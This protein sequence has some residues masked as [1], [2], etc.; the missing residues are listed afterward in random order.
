MKFTNN[1]PHGN[2]DSTV[3]ESIKLIA[4]REQDPKKPNTPTATICE[5]LNRVSNFKI[6]TA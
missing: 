6:T 2:D 5:N 3:F 4:N 1:V